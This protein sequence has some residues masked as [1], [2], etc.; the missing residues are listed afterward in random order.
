LGERRKQYKQGGKEE[1]WRRGG[2][3]FEEGRVEPDLVFGE[4]KALK[5]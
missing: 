5:I 1:K 2:K 4:R 3:F